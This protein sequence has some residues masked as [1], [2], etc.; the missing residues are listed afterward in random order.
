MTKEQQKIMKALEAIKP[1]LSLSDDMKRAHN[2]LV[3]RYKAIEAEKT[4]L[5][6][7]DK[8]TVGDI[9]VSIWGYEQS[10]V[11]F[12]QVTRKTK[13]TIALRRLRNEI[14]ET[15]EFYDSV[16]PNVDYPS[17]ESITRKKVFDCH[18]LISI[19][20]SGFKSAMLWNG[21]SAKQTAFGRG[22]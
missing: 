15:G 22:H 20:L 17:E 12:F 19:K 2:D 6:P 1:F 18:D 9:F 4:E 11:E 7:I 8:V 3:K 21:K 10:N 13:S 5:K 16:I 14:I